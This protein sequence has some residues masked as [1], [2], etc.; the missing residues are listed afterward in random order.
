MP[1][2]PQKSSKRSAP[3]SDSDDDFDLEHLPPFKKSKVLSGK[4]QEAAA[5]FVAKT[6]SADFI[7]PA[8]IENATDP[9]AESNNPEHEMELKE[10]AV[11]PPTCDDHIEKDKPLLST[12]QTELLKI[13][14]LRV[15][16]RGRKKLLTTLSD[17]LYSVNKRITRN[18]ADQEKLEDQIKSFRKEL[19]TRLEG[20]SAELT[21]EITQMSVSQRV[22]CEKSLADLRWRAKQL[23]REKDMKEKLVNDHKSRIET[24]EGEIDA[25]CDMVRVEL[26]KE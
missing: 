18:T 17:E 24:T 10:I 19:R 25:F 11:P 14:D 7:N 15:L 1:G 23:E 3:L 13:D 4:P 6:E 21:V 9:K 16:V 20:K 5:D 12:L 26:A 2:I 8:I 22:E